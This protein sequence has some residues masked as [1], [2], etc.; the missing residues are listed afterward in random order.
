MTSLWF[1]PYTRVL[2][3]PAKWFVSQREILKSTDLVYWRALYPSCCY[4]E[5]QHASL[6]LQGSFET[7]IWVK[8]CSCFLQG[9][10]EKWHQ[11]LFSYQGREIVPVTWVL[12]GDSQKK[13]SRKECS[14]PH[15]QVAWMRAVVCK[16][17][18]QGRFK[19]ITFQCNYFES[20][21]V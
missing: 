9:I 7:F 21:P 3:L 8:S 1:L 4:S 15:A 5:S 19:I 12:R 16:E 13:D 10:G 11:T 20:P 17:E 6:L 14:I 18:V 2:S